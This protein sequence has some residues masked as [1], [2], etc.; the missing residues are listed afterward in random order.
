MRIVICDDNL[1]DLNQAEHL[2]RSY[3]DS[4][5]ER[6]LDLLVFHHPDDFLCAFELDP[7]IHLVL[8]DMVLPFVSGIQV[9]KAI[10]LRN[11]DVQ[12][13]CTSSSKDFAIESY[14]VKAINYLLKPMKQETLFPILDELWNT[15][16]QQDQPRLILSDRE[17]I[18]SI[19][20]FRIAYVEVVGHRLLIHLRNRVVMT[21]TGSL[22]AL[23][24]L[25][26]QD[27]HFIQ[28]HKSYLVNLNA[29]SGIRESD[30][31]MAD[32][33]AVPIARSAYKKIKT[34]YLEHLIAK[35]QAP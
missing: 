26:R 17:S 10:R 19:S 16:N 24:P 7:M 9:A 35:G 5:P 2:L 27:P 8:M 30:F 34:I 21:Q 29:V 6:V 23:L 22:K 11:P 31:V 20:L 3:S 28:T 15:L 14:S 13:L 25:F 33:Q 1:Q 18:T 12:I 32:Q 4:H